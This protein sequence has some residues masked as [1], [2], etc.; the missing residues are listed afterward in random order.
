[1]AWENHEE[2]AAEFSSAQPLPEQLENILLKLY[3]GKGLSFER[4]LL[5]LHSGRFFG[6]F[7]I[8]FIDLAALCL[9]S[10]ALNGA[11]MWLKK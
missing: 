3:R 7:G 8:Y 4:M 9:I 2:M 11:W 1:L 5:D 10:L 6:G